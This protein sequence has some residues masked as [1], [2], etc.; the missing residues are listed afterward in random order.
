MKDPPVTVRVPTVDR[1]SMN[2]FVESGTMDSAQAEP[3]VAQSARGTN[4]LTSPVG[5]VRQRRMVYKLRNCRNQLR[6]FPAASSP[7][8]AVISTVFSTRI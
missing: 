6:S 5:N 3:K 7:K 1:K 4:V 2:I 8:M